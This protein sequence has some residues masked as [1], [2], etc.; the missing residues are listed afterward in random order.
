MFAFLKN[1]L[2]RTPSN[3]ATGRNDIIHELKAVSC[4]MEEVDSLY[5]LTSDMDLIDYYILEYK[6]LVARHCYLMRLVKEYDLLCPQETV[7]IKRLVQ[8]KP[9]V[10]VPLSKEPELSKQTME[11]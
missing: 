6:A 7:E 5:N 8:E 4:R 10:F 3:R 2:S 1:I 11:G 9:K